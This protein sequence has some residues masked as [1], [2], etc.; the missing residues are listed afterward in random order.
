MQFATISAWGLTAKDFADS[1]IIQPEVELCVMEAHIYVFLTL[2]IFMDV[3]IR[4]GEYFTLFNAQR[5]QRFGKRILMRVIP[6]GLP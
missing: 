1:R 3:I 6:F 4:N 5:L 2:R